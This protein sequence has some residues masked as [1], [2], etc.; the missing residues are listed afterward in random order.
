MA[1]AVKS[2]GVPS[3]SSSLMSAF[4]PYSDS[5]S[6]PAYPNNKRSSTYGHPC[7]PFATSLSL[8]LIVV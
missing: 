5:P 8:V 7:L 4:S 2:P 3:P 6:S 1:A